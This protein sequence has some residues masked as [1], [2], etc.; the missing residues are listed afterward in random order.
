MSTIQLV[1]D[2]CHVTFTTTLGRYNH[3]IKRD[4]TKHFCSRSCSTLYRKIIHLSTC[5]VCSIDFTPTKGAKGIYC[6]RKCSNTDLAKRRVQKHQ[7][8]TV[9]QNPKAPSDRKLWDTKTTTLQDWREK[10]SP[11]QYHA[12]IRGNSRQIYKVEGKP[13]ACAVCGYTNFV[14]IAH[15]REVRDFPMGTLISE[16]NNINNL[17]AL[18]PNHHHEL[19]GGLIRV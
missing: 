7:R 14:D 12:K 19:D 1:C 2:H 16:V 9:K 6:S 15:I 4:Q 10:Y 8:R 5:K 3:S 13:L 17:V 18:C 11:S